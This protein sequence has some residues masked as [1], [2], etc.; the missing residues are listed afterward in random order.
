MDL[1][2]LEYA[3]EMFFRMCRE[4][5]EVCPHD[6]FWTGTRLLDDSKEEEHYKCKLCGDKKVIIK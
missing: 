2:E 6:Y 1:R 3:A 5:P 4:H